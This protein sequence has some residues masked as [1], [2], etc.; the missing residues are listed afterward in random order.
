MP[1]PVTSS[2]MTSWSNRI[3]QMKEPELFCMVAK[4][5]GLSF[6][7]L[8]FVADL[9]RLNLAT[10]KPKSRKN[11]RIRGGELRMVPLKSRTCARSI[12]GKLIHS[13]IFEFRGMIGRFLENVSQ[14]DSFF[15]TV[16]QKIL[17]DE[18][19]RNESVSRPKN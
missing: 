14:T 1:G 19:S 2:D 6:I 4:F 13:A 17:M 8:G 12:S 16:I 5:C 11:S 7:R 3:F 10:F 9:F 15:K 18:F